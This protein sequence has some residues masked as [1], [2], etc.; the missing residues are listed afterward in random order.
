M[1]L[2]CP[3]LRQTR[4]RFLW[5]SALCAGELAV[6]AGRSVPNPVLLW[7]EAF[8][9]W[10][11]EQTPPPCLTSR[12]L[13]LLHLALWRVVESKPKDLSTALHHAASEVC[14]S[15]FPTQSAEID[16]LLPVREGGQGAR[17]IARRVLDSRAGDGSST[18]VH[19]VP[20][21]DP[22]QWRRTPP[23]N[24]PP[25]LPHWR[26]VTPFLLKSADQF[27][28]PVPPSLIGDD[29]ARDL[30]EVQRLG[31]K[32]SAQRT[33]FET[34]SAHFWSDFSYTTSPPGHWNDI[35]RQLA[36]RLDLRESAR[37]FAQ[38]NLALADT[39]IATWDC[40]YHYNF[41]RPVTAVQAS[42][43]KDWLPVLNTPPHPEYVSGHSAFSGAA[44]AVLTSFFGSDK[45][46]FTASS[47]TVKEKRREYRS[48]QAC[49]VEISQSRVFG[50][51]HFPTSCREGLV[52]GRKVGE[53]TVKEF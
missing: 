53:W 1:I 8:Q 22:G 37:L 11:R 50:G 6:A 51:I 41:W 43:A 10:V 5:G 4:R 36:A 34:E 2:T 3:T 31:G 33:N 27:R 32:I 29:F 42:G 21:S 39:A 49:A 40:K 24:R 25:E 48:P 28:P 38:L 26:N 47:D 30:E 13:A 18:T 20:R 14:S 7:N 45:L 52:L 12:N 44:V 17:E 15:L 16:Q 46:R 35:A 9:R 23:T 19:Y